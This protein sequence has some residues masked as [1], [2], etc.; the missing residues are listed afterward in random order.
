MVR[1]P[2]LV[3]SSALAASLAGCAGYVPG[4]GTEAVSASPTSEVPSV[5]DSRRWSETHAFFGDRETPA[6]ASLHKVL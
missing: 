1:I 4:A 2:L 6:S 5:A 3:T